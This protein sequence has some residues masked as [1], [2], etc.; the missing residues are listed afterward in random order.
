VAVL[1][2]VGFGTVVVAI[3]FGVRWQF[4]IVAH[5]LSILV[6]GAGFGGLAAGEEECGGEKGK[7]CAFHRGC[8]VW[9]L[10]INRCCWCCP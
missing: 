2:I 8:W 7:K 3:A 1:L 5:G 4:A 6:I 9:G 10:C